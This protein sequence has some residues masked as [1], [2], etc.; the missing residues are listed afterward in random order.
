[1]RVRQEALEAMTRTYDAAVSGQLIA[2]A[3]G[4]QA[5]RDTAA[6]LSDSAGRT[7]ARTADVEASA[8]QAT[9]NA[10]IVAAAADQL[11]SSCKEIASQVERSSNATHA[12][13]EHANRARKLV[14]ELTDVVVGT[15]QVV[16]LIN[17]IAGQTNLLALNATIEAARAGDAGKGF[18]VV[19]QEVKALATQ[20]ARATGDIS[21]R[22]EAVRRSAGGATEVIRQM[23][24][25]M[26]Q[27]DHTT[28]AI[29]AAV[30][31]QVAATDEI[32]RNVNESSHCTIKVCEGIAVVRADATEVL[33]ASMT[34]QQAALGLSQQSRQFNDD[35]GDF[36]KAVAEHSDRR[37]A[38]RFALSRQVRVQSGSAIWHVADLLDISETG[39][40]I[41]VD[42]VPV[43][44]GE[45][46]IGDLLDTILRG[47][48][49]DV[50]DGVIR[51]QFQPEPGTREMLRRLIV[52]TFADAA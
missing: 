32:S 39:A 30:T 22:I 2:A 43:S 49:V 24:D 35:V 50:I 5:L 21:Q 45:I 13:T 12:L 41:R 47:R 33:T 19:A 16:D 52:L 26:Q 29:A 25:L 40:A 15:G 11:A 10:G 28:T 44:G 46:M 8:A 51:L 6:G 48:V 27:F 20:T 23:A 1:M 9:E 18:A 14:D 42:F 17:S 4:A 38:R 3:A 37:S 7:D 31:Q 36:L 34:V